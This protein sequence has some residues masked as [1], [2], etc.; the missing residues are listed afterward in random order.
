MLVRPPPADGVLPA[1]VIQ[2]L[3]LGRGALAQP[4]DKVAIHYV[5]KRLD[6]SLCETTHDRPQPLEFTLGMG[7]V[8]RGLDE[9]VTGMRVGGVRKLTVPMEFGYARHGRHP[10]VLPAATLVYDVELLGVQ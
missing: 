4:G 5:V 8:I 3:S 2:D 10:A 9:G 7:S 1:L 6:G